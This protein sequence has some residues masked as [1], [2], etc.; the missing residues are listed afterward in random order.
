MQENL[1]LVEI[2]NLRVF[3]FTEISA[4]VSRVSLGM[5]LFINTFVPNIQEEYFTGIPYSHFRWVEKN[6]YTRIKIRRSRI[7]R[8]TT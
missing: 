4:N 2:L 8:W 6:M 7:S 5:Y 3:S 1:P